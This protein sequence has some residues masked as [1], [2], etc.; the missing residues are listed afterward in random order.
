[1][2][3]TQSLPI[4]TL[5]SNTSSNGIIVR[6]SSKTEGD[7]FNLF[8]GTNAPWK[9]GYSY[10]NQLSSAYTTATETGEKKGEY[11]EIA[12]SNPVY[13]NKFGIVSTNITP[14]APKSLVI[15]GKNQNDTK[16]KILAELSDIPQDTLYINHRLKDYF[17]ISNPGY[18]TTYRVVIPSIHEKTNPSAGYR[19]IIQSFNL[20]NI[21][22]TTSAPTTTTSA[23]TT[24]ISKDSSMNNLL[25][26][27]LVLLFLVLLV[28]G[29]LIYKKMMTKNRI[30]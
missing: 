1:M 8:D 3:T 23:P 13:A 4:P 16:F 5:T 14:S 7:A 9:S 30:E 15:L 6:A 26:I 24:T 20:Y 21:E 29:V 10:V 19:V 17:N 18:Y 22:T 25:I 12:F 28:C 11:F 27:F 2:G